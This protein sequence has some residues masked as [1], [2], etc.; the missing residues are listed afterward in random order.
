MLSVWVRVGD[1]SVVLGAAEVCLCHKP[2]ELSAAI[3]HFRAHPHP[4]GAAQSDAC[5]SAHWVWV[6]AKVL[7]ITAEAIIRL[8]HSASH[9]VAIYE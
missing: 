4:L 6:R 2:D 9:T 7:N 5:A 8:H 3:Q 1:N